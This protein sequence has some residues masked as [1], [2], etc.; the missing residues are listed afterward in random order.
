MNSGSSRY[1]RPFCSRSASACVRLAQA[2]GRDRRQLRRRAALGEI[3]RAGHRLR[4]H[5]VGELPERR[6]GLAQR[7]GLG[8]ALARER[9][10]S[11]ASSRL[12]SASAALSASPCCLQHVA[13]L[14]LGL[15]ELA[16]PV[17]I[18]APGSSRTCASWRSSSPSCSRILV[19]S[20]ALRAR[21]LAISSSSRRISRSASSSERRASGPERRHV[22]PPRHGA[23]E[24]RHDVVRRRESRIP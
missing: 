24:D 3:G 17:P 4:G 11:A 19:T 18:C 12:S 15:A 22:L 10:R 2:L 21:R 20:S 23:A 16:A 14:E 8:F 1:G 6:L 7:F 13:R 5:L 9:R